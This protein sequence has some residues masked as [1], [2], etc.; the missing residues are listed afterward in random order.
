[1]KTKYYSKFSAINI[2]IRINNK[3]KYLILKNTKLIKNNSNKIVIL[4]LK[5]IKILLI[6]LEKQSSEGL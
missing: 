4:F 1:M 6:Y 2:L 5:V 3:I